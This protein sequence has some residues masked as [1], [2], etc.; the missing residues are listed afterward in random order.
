MLLERALGDE[1]R[2]VVAALLLIV[3]PCWVWIVAMG[4]DMYGS[5]DGWSAWSMTLTWGWRATALLFAMW[6][7]MMIGMMLPVAAPVLLLYA[8]VVRSSPDRSQTSVRVAMLATGYLA[9]WLAFSLA[10]TLVQRALTMM[11]VLT[12]MMELRSRSL[13]GAVLL[14]AGAYQL[15][16]VKTSCLHACRSAA[17]VVSGYWRRGAS[18]AFHMGLRHGGYC[19]GCCWALMLLLFAGGVMNVVIVA[20]ITSMVLIERIAPRGGG[21]A[22]L[23]G[24]GLIAAGAWMF[25]A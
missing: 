22:R 19:L 24:V 17:A 10:A 9:V 11:A 16:P 8:R 20:A 25:A 4:V 13:A 7:A 14:L 1:R 12:P 21:F 2:L 5:M 15:T 6:A 23:A 18:G 3:L